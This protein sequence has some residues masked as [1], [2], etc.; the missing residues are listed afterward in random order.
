MK[1][2]TVSWTVLLGVCFVMAMSFPAW[3]AKTIKI[4]VI[5]PMNFVQGKGHWNG[6]VMA[7]EKIN[8]RGGI[9]VGNKKMKIKLVKADSNEFLNVM[10]ATNAMELILT[11]DKV[12]F[13]VG[14]FR[15]EAVLAM[16]DIAMDYKKIFIG[17]GAAHPKLCLRV[18]GDYKRYKYFFRGTPFN[19]RYLVKTCFIQMAT[20]GAILKKVLNIPKVKVAIVAEKA[21]WVDPMIKA[22]QGFIPKMGMEVVG[23]W[24]PSAVATDVTA[25]LSAVQ[26]TGAH[27]IFTTFSSS[28]GIPFARQAGELE[29]PAVQVGINV[30]A[31][32]DGFWK[33]TQGM[34]NYV[35]TLNTYCR[36]VEANVLTKP[37]VETY[38]KR[39]GE[40]PTYTA[41]TYAA[42]VYNLA[43]AIEQAGT[44]D[45]DKLIPIMETREYLSPGGT[46][47]YLKDAEG[48]HLHDLKWGPGYLTSL[49]VQ[50]QDGK[51]KGVWPNRWKASKDAP[52]ITYKGIVPY[53]IPPW[54]I[55]KYKK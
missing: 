43:P 55:K 41:D 6:A 51:L 32:K 11:R 46:V 3:G 10:D 7:M 31:Q 45:A 40:V 9:Q 53:K 2:T 36:D 1:K 50:W 44:L 27:M 5:G 20:V 42:I 39:F 49:G 14:G 24:R 12:D 22:A 34:G 13:I 19:S 33:A 37:F 54:V 18:A 26:R 15:S 4:G 48:R 47:G 25:E 35:M 8:A 17:C 16:Q 52:A 28:V 38:I 23:T 21:M 30:E 29:V